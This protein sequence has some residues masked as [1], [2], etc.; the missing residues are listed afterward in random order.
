MDAIENGELMIDFTAGPAIAEA[1]GT[2]LCVPVFA[3]RNWGPGA[4]TA[5][6]SVG[7]QI[8][9][10]LDVA[11]FTGKLGQVAVLAGQRGF[12]TYAFVG[13]GE[14]ADTEVI[15]QAAGWLGRSVKRVESVSTTFHLLDVE[16]AASAFAEGFELA[17]YRFDRH[18]SEPQPAKVRKVEFV[19]GD[20]EAAAAAAQAAA[21]GLRGAML[22]RDLINEPANNKS[23]ETLAGIATRIAEERGLRIRVYEPDEFGNERF[24]GLAGVAAG[25][26]NPA[27]LVELWY[28]PQNPRAFVALVGKGIVFDS[29]GLSLKPAASME[30]MKTDMSG[31]AVVFGAVQAIAEAGLPVKVV[32]ITPIT[33]NM[34]GGG[35]TRPGDVLIAR[36]GISIEVLNTDAEGRLV[37]ADGL[38][39]AAEYQPDVIVDVAT[40]TGACVTA[41]GE[42]IGGLWSNDQATA[43][44]ILHA[45]ARTGERFWHMPLP[46]DYRKAMDSDVA[47]IKNISGSRYG[48][49]IYAALFL[50]E[51]VGETKWAHLDIAG[52]ARWKEEEHYYLKGGSGF[53]VRTLLAL[54]EDLATESQPT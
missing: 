14:E 39:L 48:G 45:S 12:T 52:P 17:L 32:G 11:D 54:A 16:G 22:T 40:L 30:D 24:G 33:E 13:L 21:P 27:R 51:Y 23:P 50:K 31:A 18:R 53:G 25:A 4:D 28:E 1:E 49:A 41:L 42:K 34:P 35:A 3:D 6:Q 29:G 44:R 43:E 2:V 26:D 9:E 46:L 10:L 8:D 19:G 15:R 36:N 7:E 47:D 37:L 20:G 38:S 5:A